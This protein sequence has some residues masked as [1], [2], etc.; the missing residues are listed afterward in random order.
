MSRPSGLLRLMWRDLLRWPGRRRARPSAQRARQWLASSTT[1]EKCSPVS[2]SGDQPLI[3]S[4]R[5]GHEREAPVGVGREHDVGRVLDQEP[6]ALLRLAQLALEALLLGHVAD[7]ALDRRRTGRPRQTDTDVISAGKVVP[8]WYFTRYRKRRT[9]SCSRRWASKL[10]SAS[11]SDSSPVRSAKVMPTICAGRQPEQ[12][13]GAL[14]H[15]QEPAVRVAA[16][17]DVRRRLDQQAEARLR[18]AQLALEPVAL[19]HVAD[20]AVGPD[21]ARRPRRAVAIAMNSAGIGAPSRREQVDPAAELLRAGGASP[22]VQST[23]ATSRDDSW[24]SA[25]KCL[26]DQLLGPDSRS[27]ARPASDTNVSRASASIDQT[28]SGAFSTR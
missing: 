26:P 15:E 7:G 18:F 23:S 24:T 3:R 14:G 22:A 2:S 19:A 10:A 6:V 5:L 11:A 8:S 25:P 17:D 28:M 20:R 16:I 13:L 4:H 12:A 1:F 21:E 27:A 9:T